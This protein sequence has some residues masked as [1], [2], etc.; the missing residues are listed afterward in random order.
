MS[1]KAPRCRL[2]D[3]PAKIF[4]FEVIDD[5]GVPEIDCVLDCGHRI[6]CVTAK[7]GG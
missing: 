7:A 3:E 6:R 1:E 5:E 2:C 4:T